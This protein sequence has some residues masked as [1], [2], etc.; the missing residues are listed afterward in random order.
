MAK[1][2][3]DVAA[4]ALGKGHESKPKKEGKGKHPKE[5]HV[6]RGAS[7][8]YIAKHLHEPGEDGQ[9]PPENGEEHVLPDKAAMLAHMDE[10]MGDAEPMQAQGGEP[11]AGA[12]E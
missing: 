9:M 2:V 7:G 3:H 1:N 12:A 11:D 5:V 4:E 8:G 10:H 6:R